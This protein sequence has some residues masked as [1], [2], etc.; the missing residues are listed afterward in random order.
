MFSNKGALLLA[1]R[2]KGQQQSAALRSQHSEGEPLI[3]CLNVLLIL[4]QICSAVV[5]LTVPQTAHQVCFHLSSLLHRVLGE[6]IPL[7]SSEVMP[8]IV[9]LPVMSAGFVFGVAAQA[10]QGEDL[11]MQGSAQW[12]PECSFTGKLLSLRE[13][14]GTD[15]INHNCVQS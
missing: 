5:L 10:E 8:G 11:K 14:S 4:A 9:L 7:G 6:M 13:L 15:V 12:M 3:S 1:E 2:A